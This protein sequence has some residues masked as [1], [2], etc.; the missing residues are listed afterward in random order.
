[1]AP[2]RST[3]ATLWGVAARRTALLAAA[4]AGR[5]DLARLDPAR[6]RFS[7]GTSIADV[8][9]PVQVAPDAAAIVSG[10]AVELALLLAAQHRRF[11]PADDLDRLALVDGSAALPAA[12]AT[13]GPS[14]GGPDLRAAAALAPALHPALTG[15]VVCAWMGK[16]GRGRSLT[17]LFIEALG[18]A[19]AEMDPARGGEDTPLVAALAL[20]SELAAAD[21]RVRALLPAT[22]VGRYL[23][24]AAMAGAWLS[25]ATGL[26]RAL[27][28]GGRAPND[29]LALRLEAVV[30]PCA[31]LGGKGAALHGVTIYGCELPAGV[32]RGDELLARLAAGAD[33][34]SV[35][36]AVAEALA[37][38][39]ELARRAE[40]AVAV[41][42]VRERLLAGVAAAEAA[43]R[44]EAAGAL[45]DLY[46]APG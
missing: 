24:S 5:G 39:D 34:E 25:A 17:A 43:G 12:A 11:L 40:S 6:L 18:R 27:R 19:I 16:G 8:R 35:V 46:A 9:V 29:A 2:P 42:C 13:L 33:A 22:P 31:L 15:G 36:A 1:M 21:A 45:R 23:G 26:A 4:R 32:P 7:L 3:E 28:G 44:G 14:G 20:T 38:D 10:A 37:V 41:A 30:A